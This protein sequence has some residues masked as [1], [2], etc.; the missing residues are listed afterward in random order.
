M[1]SKFRYSDLD[2]VMM[3]K[4]ELGKI[5]MEENLVTAVVSTYKFVDIKS[6]F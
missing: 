2:F 1:K 5:N 6:V 4:W 3:G